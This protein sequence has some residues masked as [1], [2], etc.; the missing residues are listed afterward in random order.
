VIP[1]PRHWRGC[2][3]CDRIGRGRRIGGEDVE[4]KYQL[5][6]FRY[7][8]FQIECAAL[9]SGLADE[10]LIPG[11]LREIYP[12]GD[13]KTLRGDERRGLRQR[14]ARGGNELY[15]VAGLAWN[16]GVAAR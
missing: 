11:R 14:G 15:G 16:E 12:R 6:V 3:D 8:E 4:I 9:R 7:R 2:S 1:I 10:A 13:R 5:V